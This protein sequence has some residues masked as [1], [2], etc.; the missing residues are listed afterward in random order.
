MGGCLNLGMLLP[1][2]RDKVFEAKMF[3]GLLGRAG[4]FLLI[5]NVDVYDNTTMKNSN[6]FIRH[7]GIGYMNPPF[8]FTKSKFI[9]FGVLPYMFFE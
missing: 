6:T 3:Q 1:V 2:Q 8:S 4:D 7:F 5:F 9:S